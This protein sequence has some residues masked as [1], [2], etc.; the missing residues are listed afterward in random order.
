VGVAF[1]NPLCAAPP[2]APAW[3]YEA[4]GGSVTVTWPDAIGQAT[5]YT[6]GVGSIAGASNIGTFGVGAGPSFA[7]TAAP[8]AY[9][10]RLRAAGPC[11][12]SAPSRDTVITVGG[13]TPPPAPVVEAQVAGSTVTVTWTA[14]Q[15]AISYQLDA[16]SGPLMSDVAAMPTGG[17]SLV[18]N[19]VPSGTYYLRVHAVA[20]GGLR[21]T[22]RELVV[23]VP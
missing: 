1:G 14:V 3:S 16:G 23:V 4:L 10:A 2:Q 22:S 20:G 11:G 17:T 19:T 21:S 18:A 9:F 7:A 12:V 5:G 6:L 13:V 8:G 15:G